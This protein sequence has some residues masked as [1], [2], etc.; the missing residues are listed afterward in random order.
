[1]S[2]KKTAQT[3]LESDFAKSMKGKKPL[4]ISDII[5]QNQE[6]I[7]TEFLSRALVRAL[8]QSK[9]FT[10]TNA[11]VGS[12]ANADS[13]INSVRT[14]N[15]N[16]SQN[17]KP[18]AGTIIAPQYSLSGKITKSL[19]QIGDKVRADYLFLF[20]LTDLKTG[21]VVWD[22]EEVISKIL[23]KDY[24]EKY[25]AYSTSNTQSTQSGQPQTAMKPAKKPFFKERYL[26]ENAKDWQGL[27]NKLMYVG[28]EVGYATSSQTRYQAYNIEDV[29]VAVDAGFLGLP[30]SS[31]SSG[32]GVKI[33]GEFGLQ[34]RYHNARAGVE[35]YYHPAIFSSKNGY[36]IVSF[37]A[38]TG[39]AIDTTG[40][41]AGGYVDMG[42]L[43][44]PSSPAFASLGYRADFLPQVGMQHSFM[45]SFRFS[46]LM[47]IALAALGI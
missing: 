43:L 26:S 40:R 27:N 11:F 33:R 12:G 5:N 34:R 45:I 18:Q 17:S 28:L 36:Q 9:K 39:A 1:M 23:N 38:G 42:V 4:A 19:K 31:D 22:H 46:A 16:Y 30:E 21:L 47:I 29:R 6:Y 10:L 8:R 14:L 44:F 41:G 35:G 13:A 25:G 24:V 2:S 15:N 37:Y 7:D 20:V 3:L 32:F